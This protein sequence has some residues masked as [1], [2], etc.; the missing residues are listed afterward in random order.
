MSKTTTFAKILLA[1]SALLLSCPFALAQS[2]DD[3]QPPAPPPAKLGRDLP[4]AKLN[5]EPAPFKS[6]LKTIDGGDDDWFMEETTPKKPKK[7]TPAQAANVGVP[8]TPDGRIIPLKDEDGTGVMMPQANIEVTNQ[9]VMPG[10][11][12]P[13]MGGINPYYAPGMVPYGY[14]TGGISI[15]L[16]RAGTLN[17]GGGGYPYGYGGY[18]YPGY[19]N[20]GFGYPAVN[21]MPYNPAFPSPYMGMPGFNGTGIGNMG[22]FGGPI[23]VPAGVGGIGLPG[24]RR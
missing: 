21:G 4:P 18:G 5:T 24:I 14:N 1:S 22:S 20:P 3:S 7:L 12:V 6:P 23:N 16:G 10:Y 13:Y 9:Y 19:V 11:G 15:G 2:D 17:L 8:L